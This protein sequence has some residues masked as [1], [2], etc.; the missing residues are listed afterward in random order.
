M[1]NYTFSEDIQR[2][3]DE[4]LKDK[5][6]EDLIRENIQNAIS[7]AVKNSF[8]YGDLSRAVEK[9]IKEVL[10]PYIETYDMQEFIPKLDTV[11]TD[12]V[13]STNLQDNKKILEN[14][15][16]LMTEPEEKV[17]SLETL[18]D[19]YCKYAA[20]DIDTSN[21]DV[22]Y[23]DGY[24]YESVEVYAVTDDYSNS[25]SS[26]ERIDVTF[27]VR[28]I[29]SID[30]DIKKFVITLSKWKRDDE[31][32]YKIMYLHEP[33]IL[34]LRDMC[35]FEALLLKLTRAG[36]KVAGDSIE[37]MDDEVTPEKEPEPTWQ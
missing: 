12:I 18:F 19:E 25:S 21:L 2:I 8:S 35:S 31:D 4:V 1:P 5:S 15:R 37:D 36:V 24:S 9:K 7:N 17:I 34:S 26:F 27:G 33:N 11:L 6:T 14:F 10:V 32:N 22:E 28:D 16:S 20:H 30:S 13:N 29:E 3:T 23:S